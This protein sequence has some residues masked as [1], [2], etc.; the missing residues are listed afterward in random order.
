M[1]LEKK[2]IVTSPGHA[3]PHIMYYSGEKQARLTL[4][5]FRF[6]TRWTGTA[7]HPAFGARHNVFFG[8]VE[9]TLFLNTTALYDTKFVVTPRTTGHSATLLTTW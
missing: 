2:N 5:G 1:G 9:R 3:C 4:C 6:G 8:G 7:V